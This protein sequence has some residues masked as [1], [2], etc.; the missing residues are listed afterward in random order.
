LR[1]KTAAW[2]AAQRTAYE[3][4]ASGEAPGELL[5]YRKPTGDFNPQ[6]GIMCRIVAW[7]PRDR[8]DGAR[9]S[10]D[11]LRDRPG[12]LDPG[13]CRIE[14]IPIADLREAIRANR[15]SFPSQVPT[16]P[17]HDRPD[18][19][20]QL[21]QLYFVLGWNC[22]AIGT[23]YGLAPARIRQILDRWR[24]RAVS[25]GYI[26]EIP[27]AGMDQCDSRPAGVI[28]VPKKEGLRLR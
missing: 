14:E 10:P 13:G 28:E 16:F 20:R 4:I 22:S 17:K 2:G 26:Q 3:K 6:S 18:L 21:A 1:L 8:M 11:A 24:R 27:S 12:Q 25:A 19:Q 7:L 23:R 5:F 15:V 9:G